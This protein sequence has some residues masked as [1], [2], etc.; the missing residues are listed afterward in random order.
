MRSR[1]EIIES[2]MVKFAERLEGSGEFSIYGLNSCDVPAEVLNDRERAKSYILENCW[3]DLF[4]GIGE[5]TAA[6]LLQL[7]I[8]SRD[9]M[10][11]ILALL[12]LSENA[13]DESFSCW[14]NPDYDYLKDEI[15]AWL[16]ASE[17]R[18]MEL[19][20]RIS[21]AALNYYMNYSIATP[22]NDIEQLKRNIMVGCDLLPIQPAMES[23]EIEIYNAVAGENSVY[24]LRGASDIAALLSAPVES[25][26]TPSGDEPPPEEGK[27]SKR[28]GLA[29][30]LLAL[31]VILTS[32]KKEGEK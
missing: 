23:G 29:C 26:E 20:R 2:Q 17:P 28:L 9:A 3:L 27:T 1:I 19:A 12:F 24:R 8:S 31:A 30:L 7:Y 11:D 18:D 5:H 10:F 14:A 15:G 13:K 25:G 32:K 4:N 6:L 22:R 16:R 21:C